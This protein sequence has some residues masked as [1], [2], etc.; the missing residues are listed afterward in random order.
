MLIEISSGGCRVLCGEAPE[1]GARLT[2]R[3]PREVADGRALSLTGRV[4]R[5]ERRTGASAD[6]RYVFAFRFEDLS[7]RAQER[8]AVILQERHTGP[9]TLLGRVKQERSEARRPQRLRL[10]LAE[11][12][13]QREAATPHSERRRA[14]RGLM[15]QEVVALDP[16]EERVKHVLLGRDLSVG[17]MRVEPHPELALGDRIRLAIYEASSPGAVL[18]E[19]TV[20]RDDRERG[21]ALRFDDVSAEVRDRLERMISELPSVEG[22][23]LEGQPPKPLVV[24]EIVSE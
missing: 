14:R 16:H 19:A 13:R 8:L 21:L 10:R 22:Q 9:A 15:V 11:S 3:I 1:P 4:L 20:Q 2:I 24:T 18:L 6:T 23:G 5:C 12:P 17:G 7:A